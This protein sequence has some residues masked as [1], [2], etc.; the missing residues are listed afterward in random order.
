MFRLRFDLPYMLLMLL[1]LLL[2]TSCKR[3]EISELR[4]KGT[5]VYIA[6]QY[7]D[8]MSSM[9]YCSKSNHQETDKNSS[10]TKESDNEKDKRAE[11]AL[12]VITLISEKV[13]RT[14]GRETFNIDKVE[15]GELIDIYSGEADKD[16]LQEIA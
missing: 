4:E 3:I 12:D 16:T 11:L 8:S 7:L 10:R 1:S 6:I 13:P 9:G 2:V 5:E 15:E 14:Q